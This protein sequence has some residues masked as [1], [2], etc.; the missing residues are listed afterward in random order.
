LSFSGESS[1]G[2]DMDDFVGVLFM[3]FLG[4]G[5]RCVGCDG[6]ENAVP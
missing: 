4:L 6:G 1:K 3:M 2:R 5:F